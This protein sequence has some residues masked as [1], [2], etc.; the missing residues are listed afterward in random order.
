MVLVL[1]Q[2][3]LLIPPKLQWGK[4]RLCAPI[5]KFSLC[6]LFYF[7]TL[8]VSYSPKTAG[9]KILYV[10][11]NFQIFFMIFVKIILSTLAC[12]NEVVIQWCSDQNLGWWRLHIYCGSN[13]ICRNAIP[14][15]KFLLLPCLHMRQFVFHPTFSCICSFVLFNTVLF[16]LQMSLLWFAHTLSVGLGVPLELMVCYLQMGI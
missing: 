7:I 6:F 15:I 11:P 10:C 1:S 12:W 2:L 14:C 13:S 5:S 8:Y 3:M 16:L 9:R 4:Y